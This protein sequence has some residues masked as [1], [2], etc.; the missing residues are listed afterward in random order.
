LQLLTHM[1]D[2]HNPFDLPQA[3]RGPTTYPRTPT[4]LPG[5]IE[6]DVDMDSLRSQQ[7]TTSPGMQI[8]T[9]HCNSTLK[10]Q[11]DLNGILQMDNLRLSSTEPPS[12]GHRSGAPALR[13][14]IFAH[15]PDQERSSDDFKAE[16]AAKPCGKQMFYD[17]FSDIRTFQ[18]G[19]LKPPKTKD[20]LPIFVPIYPF[21]Y[22]SV[23]YGETLR[24]KV[25]MS[26]IKQ[27]QE[28]TQFQRE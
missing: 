15:E 18:V 8:V 13:P 9:P 1:Y 28:R 27:S 14:P 23:D 22:E 7:Q 6:F 16:N 21:M 26:L 11:D 20:E 17:V 2:D 3:S 25:R 5:N 4:A 12:N 19:T 24:G 10:I